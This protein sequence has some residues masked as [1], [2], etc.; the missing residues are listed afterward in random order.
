MLDGVRAKDLG[1][2]VELLKLGT[3]SWSRGR[4]K[5]GKCGQLKENAGDVAQGLK[6][7]VEI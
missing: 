1:N 4:D 3:E 5:A 6:L 7:A 2:F